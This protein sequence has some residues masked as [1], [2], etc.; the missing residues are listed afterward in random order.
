MKRAENKT[1]WVEH[2]GKIPLRER[3]ERA[4]SEVDNIAESGIMNVR[5]ADILIPRSVG[6]RGQ[7]YKVMDLL[8]GEEFPFVEGTRLQNVTV[9]AGKGSSAPYRNAWKYAEREG[10]NVEDW[11][12]VKGLGVLDVHGEERKANVHWSQCEGVGKFDFFVKEWLD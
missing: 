3:L 7:N 2:S 4:F 1:A 5:L 8:T 12:H 10:G 11:Q 9:F 6:A